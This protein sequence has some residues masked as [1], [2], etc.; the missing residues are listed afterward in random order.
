MGHCARVP[1]AGD[2]A[3]TKDGIAERIDCRVET[4]GYERPH[5]PRCLILFDLAH[6]R[7]GIDLGAE[8]PWCQRVATA[9]FHNPVLKL[10]SLGYRVPKEFIGGP[11]AL[12]IK[13]PVGK[14]FSRPRT[15]R[16]TA[17]E[18]TLIGN[19]SAK[20]SMA[21]KL[22]R[23]TNSSTSRAASISN[24]VFIARMAAGDRIP[25]RTLRARS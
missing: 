17:S 25:F 18:K 4:R 12:K 22:P 10:L 24:C 23:S 6:I 19:R 2:T 7:C 16:P 1:I 8:H 15:G 9:A 3:R 14:K 21:S 20:S 11:N 5:Q 13:T